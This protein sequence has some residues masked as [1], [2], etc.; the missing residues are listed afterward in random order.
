MHDGS[1]IGDLPVRFSWFMVGLAVG[2]LVAAT[3]S[4]AFQGRFGLYY[5]I[6]GGLS[7]CSSFLVALRTAKRPD[8]ADAGPL[9]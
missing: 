8:P 1:C 2:L 7:A 3:V 9:A 4:F 6:A 5:L